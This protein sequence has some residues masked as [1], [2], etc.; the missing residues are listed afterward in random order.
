MHGKAVTVRLKNAKVALKHL[1]HKLLG[2]IR[3]LTLS[4]KANNSLDRE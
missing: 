3:F 4:G 2:I 1:G